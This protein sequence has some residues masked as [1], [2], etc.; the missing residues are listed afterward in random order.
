M[1]LVLRVG[2]LENLPMDG[3]LVLI[4]Y[5]DQ[6][7]FSWGGVESLLELTFFYGTVRA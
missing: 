6:G 7:K 4:Y 1:H 5:H 2:L 3:P